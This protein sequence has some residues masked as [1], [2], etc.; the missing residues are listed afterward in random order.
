MSLRVFVVADGRQSGCHRGQEI[1]LKLRGFPAVGYIGST[2]TEEHNYGS[3]NCPWTIQ[4]DPGQ[5]I[6]VTVLNFG[7]NTDQ[8]APRAGSY[9]PNKMAVCFEVAE[10]SE[11]ENRKLVTL[12]GGDSRE[13]SI[14]LSR[15]NEVKITLRGKQLLRSVGKFV[16]KYQGNCPIGA[17]KGPI[18]LA[19]SAADW[20][21]ILPHF[22]HYYF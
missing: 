13:S 1:S 6:N 22:T 14:F 12:C 10:I 8:Q 7:H 17:G 4:A 18:C 15:S 21:S 3:V 11:P 16:F 2:V 19:I 9:G 20:G 5:R